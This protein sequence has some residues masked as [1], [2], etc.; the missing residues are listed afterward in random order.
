[1][2]R[3]TRAFLILVL[4][5]CLGAAALWKWADAARAVESPKFTV[6]PQRIV[7]KTTP[8]FGIGKEF[9]V[10]VAPDGSLWAWGDITGDGGPGRDIRLGPVPKQISRETDWKQVAAGWFGL[11]ALKQD[12][13]LW[14]LGS[15][16]EGLLGIDGVTNSIPKLTRVG[17]ESDWK[18]I[19]T[20]LSHGMALKKDGSLWAWGQNSYGQVGVGFLSAREPITRVGF[21]TNWMAI[22]AG[23]FQSFALHK[24]GSI[25]TWGLD[26]VTTRNNTLPIKIG[27]ETNWA[28]ISPGDY[29]LIATDTSGGHWIIGGNAQIIEPAAA[30]N[31]TTNWVRMTVV[32]NCVQVYSGQDCILAKQTD[33]TWS[34]P[35][36]L[37]GPWP[38]QIPANFEPLAA[39]LQGRTALFLMPDGRLWA[40]GRKIPGRP[41]ITP[42]M[43]IRNT[44]AQIFQPGA[45]VMSGSDE[46]YREPFLLWEQ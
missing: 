45:A 9:A 34:A 4:L 46:E 13:S 29:H 10:M 12:G 33:G 38:R 22:S 40:I 25:W 23:A 36:L 42:L 8:S 35:E 32:T 11:L 17:T 30:P 21:E 7:P 27:T 15:N 1:V 2:K 44:L 39:H 3:S 37:S 5:L 31:P 16:T 43:K 26:F 14:G 28:S 18:E 19:K 6:G 41:Q 20:G 24:D